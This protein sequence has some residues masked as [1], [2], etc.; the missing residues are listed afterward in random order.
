MNI[1]KMINP[2][3]R[4]IFL[5]SITFFPSCK[6]DTKTTELINA[7]FEILRSKTI[8]IKNSRGRQSFYAKELFCD[9]Y[10]L[11]KQWKETQRDSFLY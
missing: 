6:E 2:F 4:L 10:R 11:S 5:F 7:G 3:L 8:S 9:E 1:L